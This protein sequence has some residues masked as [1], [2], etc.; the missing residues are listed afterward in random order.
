MSGRIARRL[1]LLAAATLGCALLG[2]GPRI[3]D[4][5]GP[6]LDVAEIPGG[7]FA[8]R[9]RLR[10]E[11][12]GIDR[13]LELIVERR[14]DRLVVVALGAFGERAFSAVQQG[15]EVHSESP[16]GRALGFPPANVLRDLHA[17]R[18]FRDDSP[19]RVEVSRP[20]CGYRAHLLRVERR[21]LD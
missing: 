10:V 18:F 13:A 17:A 9:E 6:L 2:V 5:P 8:L 7:D 11:G 19:E 4:C 3:A 16:L 21:A 12:E 20:G 14:G 15:S 1:S